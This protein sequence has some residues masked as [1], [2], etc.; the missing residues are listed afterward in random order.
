MRLQVPTEPRAKPGHRLLDGQGG[1]HGALRVVAVGDGSAEHGHD[2][3]ADV[4]V[5][6]AA[7]AVDGAIDSLKECA[8]QAMDLLRIELAR[9][10]RVASEVG[11]QDRHLPTLAVGLHRR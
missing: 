2:T 4:L 8:E 9:Q 10:P 3:V 7:V 6:G 5:D 1:A 11:E